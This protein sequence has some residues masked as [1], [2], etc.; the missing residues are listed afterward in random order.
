MNWTKLSAMAEI[1]SSV[2]IL[3]T[4]VYLA[5]QTQ[6]SADA[7]QANTR[8]AILD[9]DQQFLIK[10]MEYPEI[11][12]SQ[13][14]PALTD[15]EKVRLG[16]Y[17]ILFVRMRENNWLQYRNGV[18]DEVTWDSYRSSIVQVLSDSTSR[19][20]WQ[21]YAI[22]RRAFDSEFVSLVNELLADTPVQERS[23]LIRA[24]D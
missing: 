13:F 5:I 11:Y 24:F 22:G 12:T 18:L 23:M 20:W 16:A 4:L 2:A 17:L 21:N 6:Q 14:K 8:Q 15:E 3:V 7:I 10:V 1:L 19:G 9:A